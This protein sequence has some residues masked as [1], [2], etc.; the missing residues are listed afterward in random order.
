MDLRPRRSFLEA[1]NF[2]IFNS[3]LEETMDPIITRAER[4]LRNQIDG[5]PFAD[6]LRRMTVDSPDFMAAPAST[7][8]HHCYVGG[9]LIHTAEVVY[10]AGVLGEGLAGA[11]KDALIIAAILHDASKTRDY[12]RISLRD[13]ETGVNY[14]IE[15]PVWEKTDYGNKIYHIAGSVATFYYWLGFFRAPGQHHAS[16]IADITHNMLAHHGRKEWGSPVTPQTPAAHILHYADNMSLQ[17]GQADGLEKT[18]R[19]ELWAREL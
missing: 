14:L 6:I 13:P 3:T 2:L 4:Y 15:T 18:T 1:Q 9:L 19:C 17:L 10:Y 5:L 12:Q 7:K 8:H 11:E 16:L